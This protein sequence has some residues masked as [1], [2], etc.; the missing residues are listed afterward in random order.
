[1]N[2]VDLAKEVAQELGYTIKGVSEVIDKTF[3]IAIAEL[4]R[5]GEVSVAG[6][7]KFVVKERKS[8]NR[9]N[10]RTKQPIAVPS[11]RCVAFRESK[12]LKDTV[13]K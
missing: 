7:G 1:M 9:I 12:T 8:S 13:N 5:G 6:F 10:P 2:K 11:Y 3:E 4:A